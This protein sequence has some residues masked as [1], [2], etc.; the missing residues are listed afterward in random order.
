MFTPWQVRDLDYDSLMHTARGIGVVKGTSIYLFVGSQVVCLQCRSF[1]V[2]PQVAS[3]LDHSRIRSPLAGDATFC[4]FLA[5]L[6]FV[7]QCPRTLVELPAQRTCNRRQGYGKKGK[8]NGQI[9]SSGF[10]AALRMG[11]L[12]LESWSSGPPNPPARLPTV[13]DT[14]DG[15]AS[16][17]FF[18][19]SW[20]RWIRDESLGILEDYAGSSGLGNSLLSRLGHEPLVMDTLWKTWFLQAPAQCRNKAD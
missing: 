1:S 15:E 17:G 4:Q 7:K 13:G 10:F 3:K 11:S 6:V 19:F 12:R 20:V 2:Q 5:F 14:F 18:C 16:A 8:G 9:S